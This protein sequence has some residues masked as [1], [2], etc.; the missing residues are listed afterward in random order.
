MRCPTSRNSQTQTKFRLAGLGSFRGTFFVLESCINRL[1]EYVVSQL[2]EE[3]KDKSLKPGTSESISWYE[4]RLK[5]FKGP[6]DRRRLQSEV[7]ALRG[8]QTP[9]VGRMYLFYYVPKGMMTLPY[10]DMFPVILLLDVK[11]NYFDG[12]NM[13][14]LPLDIREEFYG[15]LLERASNKSMGKDTFI[16]ITYDMLKAF[17]KYRAFRPSYK[18]YD[19]KHVRGRVVNIP[20]SEWQIVMNLPAAQWR[21]KPEEVIHANARREYRKV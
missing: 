17:R 11:Q 1:M 7:L 10:F 9:R 13:H 6:V 14:Y 8:Y 4:E 5:Q 16:R 21:K 2:R 20:A 3:L 18:R 19:V 12:L 15:H